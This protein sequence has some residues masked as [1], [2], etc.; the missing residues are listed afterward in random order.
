MNAKESWRALRASWSIEQRTRYVAWKHRFHTSPTL[1][2]LE[3]R[4]LLN[5]SH[6]LLGPDGKPINE[7]DLKRYVFRLKNPVPLTDR[8]VG[9]Q[10]DEGAAVVINLYGRGTLK[11]SSID[12]KNQLHLVYNGTDANTRIVAQVHGGTGLAKLASIR[13]ADSPVGYLGTTAVNPLGRITFRDFDLVEGGSVQLAGGIGVLSLN[14]IAANSQLHLRPLPTTTTTTTTSTSTTAARSTTSSTDDV[15]PGL[16]LILNEVRGLPRSEQTIQA[17]QMFAY[18]AT[19]KALVRFDTG[20]GA[21]LQTIPL[22]GLNETIAGVSMGR[23]DGNLVA[24]VGDG[25][26]VRAFDAISGVA[27]GEFSIT[28]LAA[29]GLSTIDGLGS[30]DTRSFL[31][32]SRAGTNGLIVRID[33][34]ASLASGN[35]VTIGSAYSPEREFE[36]TGGLAGI[37]GSET[38]YSI[39]AARFDAFRPDTTLTGVLAMDTTGRIRETSRTVVSSPASLANPQLPGFARL[40]PNRALGSVEQRL[41]II[42]GATNAGTTVTLYNARTLAVEETIVLQT[43]NTITG[44]SESF[45]PELLDTAL[46]DVQGD[47]RTFQAN[48]AE[49]LALNVSGALNLVYIHRAKDS[50]IVGRPVEH[51]EI[52][53]RDNVTILSTA[54]DVDNN[55]TDGDTRGGVTIVRNLRPLGPLS[56]PRTTKFN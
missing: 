53:L 30:T 28:N 4:K 26:K 49:G 44:L 37:P 31:S 56:L 29:L 36:P 54:R 50:T 17:A 16:R 42:T 23:V 52:A 2:D 1:E 12:S 41:G 5:G 55:S 25:S 38:I 45:H 47:V 3:A 11:G 40:N 10:T 9:F 22:P 39:G 35:A 8:R 20:S 13:D 7:A 34:G 32:D 21:L 48:Q 33:V 18:D 14:S 6:E 19:A 46:V 15:A 27:M 24:L 43:S 51:V